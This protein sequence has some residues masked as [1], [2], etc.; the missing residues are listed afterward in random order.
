MINHFL[1]VCSTIIFYEIF[2]YI[3]FLN[4]INK[5]LKLYLKIFN[6]FKSKK[7]SDFRKEKLIFNYSKSLL[8][9]SIKILALILSI[10][11]FIFVI[12]LLSN[13]FLNLII[14]LLGIIEITIVLLIYHI[15]RKRIYAKL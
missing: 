10:I 15:L 8:I 5:S 3:D 11:T 9:I 1:L 14:S 13:S 4:F 2:K 6:L 12:N 7:V